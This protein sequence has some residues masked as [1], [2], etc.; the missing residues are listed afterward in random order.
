MLGGILIHDRPGKRRKYFNRF[1][2]ASAS[3]ITRGNVANTVPRPTSQ[4]PSHLV[5]TEMLESGRGFCSCQ[6]TLRWTGGNQV[7]T[8]EA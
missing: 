3:M 2:V 4:L 1:Q 5:Q 6:L 8:P 7:M